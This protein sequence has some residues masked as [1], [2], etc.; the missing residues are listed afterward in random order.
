MK[1][2]DLLTT[3]KQIRAIPKAE[4][5]ALLEGSNK[6]C[7]KLRQTD[8]SWAKPKTGR[9]DFKEKGGFA[10]GRA[11]QINHLENAP[12][13]QIPETKKYRAKI[14]RVNGYGNPCVDKCKIWKWNQLKGWQGSGAISIVQLLNVNEG[15]LRVILVEKKQS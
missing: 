7:R 5:P 12:G 15:Q 6:C 3:G 13:V 9:Q 4:I 8:V 10:D 1:L 2:I 14:S 11:I